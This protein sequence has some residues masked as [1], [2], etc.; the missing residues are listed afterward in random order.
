MIRK[1]LLRKEIAAGVIILFFGA[2]MTVG[3]STDLLEENT[4]IQL[5][6]NATPGESVVSRLQDEVLLIPDWT[7]DR[8]LAFDPYDGSYVEE[9]IPSDGRLSSPKCAIPSTRGTIFVSDQVS[10]AVFEYDTDGNYITTIANLASSGIDNIRGITVYNEYLYVTVYQGSHAETIQRFDL[11]GGSQLTWTSSHINSP[12]DIHF[13]SNDALVTNADSD[14]I[15]RYDHSGTWLGTFVGTGIQFPSQ[16]YERSNG[17]LYITGTFSPAG[18]YEYD[19]NGALLNYYPIDRT[20]RGVY[21]LGNG[22]L[23]FSSSASVSTYNPANGQIVDIYTDGNFQFIHL[24]SSVTNHP[25]D[26]PSD[27]SPPDGAND[28]EVDITLTWKGGDPDGDP[29]TYDVYFGTTNPPPKVV[30]NQSS[31]IY[32]PETLGYSITYY[33]QIIAWDNHS[34]STGGPIWQFTT[35]EESAPDIEIE[36][37]TGGFGVNAGIKNIGT[38]NAT[39]VNVKFT[40]AGGLILLPPGGTKIVAIGTIGGAGGTGTAK[41]FV[42]GFG[43]PTI[44][45]DVTCDEGATANATYNPKLVFLFFVLG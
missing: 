36:S 44:T 17:N 15:D 10:D 45:V 22:L 33:W 7:Y 13:R 38:V 18:I 9:I 40:V 24:L 19:Q 25:P 42:F 5:Q 20:M 14:A 43:K 34:A 12:F 41:L 1:N 21:E 39:N 3:V 31:T 6:T 11:N 28:V 4:G 35:V 37:I 27:P 16:I 29:V 30:S 8:V 23:L 32:D 26:E 2:G